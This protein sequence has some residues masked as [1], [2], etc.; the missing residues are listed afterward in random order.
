MQYPLIDLPP[1]HQIKAQSPEGLFPNP[2]PVEH[3][4]CGRSDPR[5]RTVRDP[6]IRSTQVIILISCVVIH[7]IMWELLAIS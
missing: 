4:K 7:L 5:A 3:H 2:N 1:L 6:T